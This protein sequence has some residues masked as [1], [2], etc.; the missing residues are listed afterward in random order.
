VAPACAVVPRQAKEMLEL[1][2]SSEILGVLLG[3]PETPST[4]LPFGVGIGIAIAIAAGVADGGGPETDC[5][6]DS[7]SER[8]KFLISMNHADVA[9]ASR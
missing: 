6:P 5:D 3:S 4:G 9:R 1:P 2:S 8:D 7:D